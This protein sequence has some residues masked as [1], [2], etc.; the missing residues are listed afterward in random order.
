MDGIQVLH[1]VDHLVEGRTK[2]VEFYVSRIRPELRAAVEAW[3][4]LK[5]LE[6][7]N[8]PAHPLVMPEYT[9]RVL[10]PSRT[11]VHRLEEDAEHQLRMANVANQ[12]SDRYVLFTVLL[13]SVLFFTGIAGKFDLGKARATLLVF[14]AIV[15]ASVA[16]LLF[17]TPVARA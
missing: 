10:D 2:I 4:A 16:V 15:L 1:I 3:I 17:A 13:A 7:P 11:E 14:A 9:R 5:P 6:N 12:T 8:T